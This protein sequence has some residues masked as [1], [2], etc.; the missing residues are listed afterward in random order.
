[1]AVL[2]DRPV[3]RGAIRDAHR[4]VARC[5][6]PGHR[7]SSRMIRLLATPLVFAATILVVSP[8]A[9]Q[10]VSLPSLKAAFLANFA[11]FTDFPHDA[12]P[13]GR[14]FTFC[15]SGDKAVADALEQSLKARLGQDPASVTFVASDRPTGACHILYLSGLNLRDARR[16]IEGIRDAPVFTVSD[17]EGFAEAGGVAEL[18]LEKGR[19][20]F[21]INPAAA[22][23]AHLALS[24]KLL[25]LAIIVK[26]S[27]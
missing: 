21:A 2:N 22:Q 18:R 6:L 5:S 15:V 17:L 27:Q 25:S 7:V 11:K 12:L 20:R 23:R 24:A 26:D 1:M 3:V 19:M 9:A 14:V 10:D 8:A 4:R 13:A 16:T